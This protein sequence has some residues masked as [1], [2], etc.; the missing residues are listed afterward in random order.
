[1]C[2]WGVCDDQRRLDQKKRLRF[3]GF[4]FFLFVLFFIFLS[5]FESPAFSFSRGEKSQDFLLPEKRLS[6]SL[7]FVEFVN[8]QGVPIVDQLSLK[9]MIHVLNQI[10]APCDLSFLLGEY[11]VVQPGGVG[12]PPAPRSLQ[13][14]RA[15]RK[16]FMDH[17]HLVVIHTA[18]WDHQSVGPANAWTAMPGDSPLGAVIEGKVGRFVGIIAHEL[19]HYLNLS[20]VQDD[21]NVMNPM[22]YRKSNQ[23]TESQC[24]AVRHAASVYHSPALRRVSL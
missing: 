6:L 4:C 15:F 8:E 18:S 23:I 19:G 2:G 24:K 22:I 21:S 17:R 14:M 16:P 11:E 5:L 3:S 20:H 13:E 10:Y 9:S 7:K 12:L 1:M